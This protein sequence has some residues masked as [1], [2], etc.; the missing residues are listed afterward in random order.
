VVYGP[1]G[2][3]ARVLSGKQNYG[4]FEKEVKAALK[5]T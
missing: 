4:S 3:K 5:R 2:R 1:D